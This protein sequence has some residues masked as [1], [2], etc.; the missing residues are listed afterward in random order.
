MRS[1]IRL[2]HSDAVAR[3]VEFTDEQANQ[4]LQRGWIAWTSP[5]VPDYVSVDEDGTLIE[6]EDGRPRFIDKPS[7]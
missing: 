1:L 6:R 4:Y 7:R 5:E 2:E 3:E